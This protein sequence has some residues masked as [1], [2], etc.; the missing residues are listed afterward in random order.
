MKKE[1]ANNLKLL[2]RGGSDLLIFEAVYKLLAAVIVTP[3]LY[4]ALKGAIFASG[5]SYMADNN[6]WSILSNPFTI[7]L[8]IVIL[9][10]TALYSLIEM[11]ALVTTFHYGQQGKRLSPFRMFLAGIHGAKSVLHPKN[12]LLV[13]FVLLVIPLA[14]VAVMSG[15]A[16]SIEIPEFIM[17][18]IVHTKVLLVLFAALIV[19]LVYLTIKW[20]FSIHFLVL[21]KMS[22]KEAYRRSSEMV[23][24]RFWKTLITLVCWEAIVTAV[25]F[26]VYIAVIG[27]AALGIKLIGDSAMGLAIFLSVFKILNLLLL[28]LTAAA[29]VPVCFAEISTVY[30]DEGGDVDKEVKVQ[31]SDERKGTPF[32]FKKR[33]C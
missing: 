18:T 12:F 24:G 20:I 19:F 28:F 10:L 11:S 25:L 17:D 6:M 26:V 14:G 13:V 16:A 33:Y 3:L 1:F 9:I 32:F 15:F 31:D 30:Y 2:R 27:L 4:L 5:H 22:F 23:K 29:S 21:E 8:I 7:I